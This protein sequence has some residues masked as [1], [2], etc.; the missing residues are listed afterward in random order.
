MRDP[1]SVE[2]NFTACHDDL[3]SGNIFDFL[4]NVLPS[5]CC[6]CVAKQKSVVFRFD[7]L[8]KCSQGHRHTGNFLPGGGDAVNHLPKN[9]CKLP[10][11]LRSSRKETRVM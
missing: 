11:F 8:D 1:P 3:I 7:L 9:S 10:K 4:Q 2:Y 6:Q 5:Q